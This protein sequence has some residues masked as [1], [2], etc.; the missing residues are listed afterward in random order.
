M[1]QTLVWEGGEHPFRLGIGELRALQQACD[2]GPLWIW[3]R[4]VG[5]QWMVDDVLQT[6][7]LG[8]IGGGMPEKEAR[9]LVDR[10]INPDAGF[11]RHVLLATSILANAVFGDA[12]DRVGEDEA[13]ETMTK[14]TDSRAENSS[15]QTSSHPDT[16]SD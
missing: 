15:S 5:N 14:A 8:L 10:H 12:D 16:R 13:R 4:L 9:Q 3:G 2:A 11:Y 1:Q 6:V 7:R